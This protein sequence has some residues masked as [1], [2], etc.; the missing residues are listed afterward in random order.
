[1]RL[2]KFG[3]AVTALAAAIM[4]AAASAATLTF[5]LTGN[6]SLS[7]SYGNVRN[8]S[9]TAGGETVNVQVS[10]WSLV[11]NGNNYSVQSAYLGAFSNGLGVT[12]RNEGNGGSNSHT[13]DNYSTGFDF[14]VFRFDQDVDVQSLKFTPYSVGGSTDSDAWIGIGQTDVDFASALNLTNWANDVAMFDDMYES[15]GG[16]NAST[17]NINPFDETGNLL[18]VGASMTE[19]SKKSGWDGFKIRALTVDTVPPPPPPPAV[20]E[21]ATWAMMIA[22]FGLV[23]GALRRQAGRPAIA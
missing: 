1:M 20:P 19:F 7:G 18:F 11:K 17:R 12:N 6:S 8:F 2:G 23:G 3:L 15:A 4:P 16:K 14:V 21:P 5:N 9:A 22:G 13:I 10:A